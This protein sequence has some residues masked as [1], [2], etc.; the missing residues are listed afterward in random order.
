MKLFLESLVVDCVIG[1]LPDERTRTQPLRVDVE[2]EV[3]DEA[4]RS[5]RLE[6]TVD[7]AA[8]KTKIEKALVAAKCRMIER[9]AGVVR[10]TCLAEAKV[11]AVKVRVTKSGAIP[12]LGAAAVEI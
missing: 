7:Y 11:R 10:E 9:A 6:D 12:G 3:G 8:L 2:L 4:V 1:E 5:A